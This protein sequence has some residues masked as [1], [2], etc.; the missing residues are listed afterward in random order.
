MASVIMGG[1][2]AFDALRGGRPGSDGRR[3]LQDLWD[4][5][6]AALD[7]GQRTFVE[8]AHQAYQILSDSSAAQF[9]RNM[10]GRAGSLWEHNIHTLESLD[11]FQSTGPVMQRWVM[12]NPVVREQYL[13]N[14]CDGYSDQYVNVHGN[15]IG[16]S[17]F[18]WRQVMSGV[19]VI[20]EEGV[21]YYRIYRDQ[22]EAK[23]PRLEV[24][25]KMD[26]LRS[27]N[28][29]EE[30]MALEDDDPTSVYGGSL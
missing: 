4:A 8:G 10:V 15:N 6:R 21:P 11:D 9:V 2:D 17:H 26:I 1:S 18:D 23:D 29:L 25:E 20:P 22:L 28:H 30:I 5:G 7:I 24:Y 12:A 14:Q 27:W 16:E 13:N 3:W 19:T